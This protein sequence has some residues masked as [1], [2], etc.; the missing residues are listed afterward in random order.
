MQKIIDKIR[1]YT[2]DKNE[3]PIYHPEATL[4]KHI[5]IVMFKALMFENPVLVAAALFHD[6]Y[7]QQSGNYKYKDTDK[8]YWSN[9]YHANQAFKL[10]DNNDD[11]RYWLKKNNID[12]D[13]VRDIVKYHMACKHKMIDKAKSVP[14]MDLFVR[15]DDMINRKELNA[16]KAKNVFYDKENDCL[17]VEKY[18][19][20]YISV[21][22]K[23]IPMYFSLNQKFSIFLPYVYEL[24]KKN[25]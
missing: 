20:K 23:E 14:Y 8:Q 24:L 9:P 2:D 6:I 22:F 25:K 5:L 7:K 3:H 12:A 1:K 17:K 21:N 10:L 11:I 4:Q 16:V 15:C 18:N 19:G 13:N